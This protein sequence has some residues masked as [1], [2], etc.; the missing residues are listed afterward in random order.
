MSGDMFGVAA[1]MILDPSVSV[2]ILRG[3]DRAYLDVMDDQTERLTAFYKEVLG[4]VEFA[5]RVAVGTIAN[6]QTYIKGITLEGGKMDPSK[7]ASIRRLF[8]SMKTTDTVVLQRIGTATAIVSANFNWGK[9]T[10]KFLRDNLQG[11]IRVFLE[12]ARFKALLNS[13]SPRI[14]LWVRINKRKP[15]ATAHL[16]LDTS[17]E[18]LRQITRR[19]VEENAVRKAAGIPEWIIALTGDSIDLNALKNKVLKDHCVNMMEFWNA[20]GWNKAWGRCGQLTAFAY[21]Y[22]R[23]AK[24]V[25]LG[26]RSG[27]L[28]G[29]ALIGIPTIYME[30]TDNPQQDR[31][32]KW[33]GPV[34]LHQGDSSYHRLALSTLPTRTG[35]AIKASVGSNDPSAIA[36]VLDETT[37]EAAGTNRDRLAAARAEY[38]RTG[39]TSYGE[40]FS[41]YLQLAG[42][43]WEKLDEDC[44]TWR[45]FS[46]TYP[47]AAGTIRRKAGQWYSLRV[48]KKGAE[49][50]GG[51]VSDD[52]D[53][54]M[55][56]LNV[57]MPDPELPDDDEDDVP[58]PTI[59]PPRVE[60]I[61]TTPTLT[62]TPLRTAPLVVNRLPVGYT[63]PSPDLRPPVPLKDMGKS[64]R[65]RWVSKLKKAGLDPKNF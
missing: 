53:S 20:P 21:L 32:K 12:G 7:A 1:A 18:G 56:K 27:G 46:A 39:K 9:I 60:T 6:P 19:I 54:I 17:V 37:T 44:F 29:P 51:F 36:K 15:K 11:N 42:D 25:N 8:S 52:L 14:F 64:A 43:L 58:E 23:N 24:M 30:E 35:Q 41:I 48:E 65:K 61:V 22:G 59:T 5:K 13:E 57:L 28:E 50:R 33:V 16:E 31:M 49:E 55:E 63:L 38:H 47:Q 62:T 2:I 10:D 3:T 4:D 26:M 34:R 45:D 40:F